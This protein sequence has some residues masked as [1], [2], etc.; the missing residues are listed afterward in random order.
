MNEDEWRKLN[1]N[2]YT[3][4]IKNP[5]NSFRL[6]INQNNNKTENSI[7]KSKI[8]LLLSK[9]FYRLS[10]SIFP[11][12]YQKFYKS[13][14]Y[15]PDILGPFIIYNI[16]LILICKFISSRTFGEKNIFLVI[17]KL[18]QIFYSFGYIYTLIN[19]LILNVFRIDVDYPYLVCIFGYSYNI[20][21]P[22]FIFIF[23]FQIKTSFLII[24][25]LFLGIVSS[26]SFI[27]YNI[28]Q[29]M[30][31]SS[32]N[33]K[34][35]TMILQLLS[36][37]MS[38]IFIIYLIYDNYFTKNKDTSI[39]KVSI[40][41]KHTPEKVE[42]RIFKSFI[43]NR[44][45]QKNITY[46]QELNVVHIAISTDYRNIYPSLVFLT[47]LMENIGN[48]TKYDIY[49]LSTNKTTMKLKPILESLYENYGKIKLNISYLLIGEEDFSKATAITLTSKATYYKICLP[50]LIP[51]LDRILYLDIDMINFQDLSEIN[52]ITLNEN[53]YIKAILDDTSLNKELKQLNIISDKYLNAGVLLINLKSCRKYKIEEKIKQFVKTHY[54]DHHDQTAINAICH[55]HSEV[56]DIKYGSYSFEYY[57]DF[58]NLNERQDK[59]YKY[60]SEQLYNAYH[61][62]VNIHYGGMQKPWKKTWYK[63][64]EYWWYYANKT[65]YFKEIM[66]HYMVYKNQIE[67]IFYKFE[68]RLNTK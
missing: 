34:V 48:N 46:N 35:L 54:L 39:N 16:L 22:I 65:K 24:L 53:T 49:V 25:F 18:I 8:Y 44:I 6:N 47:S 38:Y 33:K 63:F 3:N 29:K 62:P 57:D 1:I 61:Y 51:H 11:Y 58:L 42:K 60:N 23:I 27:L 43:P 66:N 52:N 4:M 45:I 56:L 67:S 15:T 64:N 50:S 59:K 14:K 68:D 10:I 40:D 7:K 5:D 13:V 30:N 9:V 26:I 31:S 21:I 37:I 19:T 17:L 32:F 12:D 28:Y 41:D 36:L 2:A 20:L 55:N